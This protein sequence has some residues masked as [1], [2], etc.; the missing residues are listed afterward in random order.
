M[1]I[2]KTIAL[3]NAQGHLIRVNAD[4]VEKYLAQGYSTHNV[5]QKATTEKAGD[6]PNASVET[7]KDDNKVAAETGNSTA[8]ETS[9]EEKA[10]GASDSPPQ[11]V[12]TMK[13]GEATMD[14]PPA[15]VP[16]FEANGWTI[17]D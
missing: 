9:T 4:E 1:A 2:V 11:D 16:K 8:T 7:T 6:A 13:K 3:Q 5:D 14:V 15:N 12:V 17:V 10:T